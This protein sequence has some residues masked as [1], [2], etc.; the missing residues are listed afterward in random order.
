MND[1]SLNSIILASTTTYI[2][3]SLDFILLIILPLFHLLFGIL[4]TFHSQYT[5]LTIN[6][7]AYG[8]QQQPRE[9]STNSY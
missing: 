4:F 6:P 2:I 3:N 8:Q 9:E 5:N 1:V 7:L